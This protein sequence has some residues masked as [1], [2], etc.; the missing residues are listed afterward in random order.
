MLR[1]H[2]LVVIWGFTAILGRLISIPP[3]EVVFYR[4]LLAALGLAFLLFRKKESILLQKGGIIRYLSIGILIAAHWILFFASA[5]VAN[6]SV[7]LAGM[8]TSSLWTS[9]LEPVIL[10]RKIYFHE[11]ILGMLVIGGLYMIF[12]FEFDHALGLSLGIGSA[13]L[14]ALFSVL[15]SK[16]TKGHHHHLITF[17]EMTGACLAIAIFFP[18]YSLYIVQGPLELVP[19]ANDWLW[20]LLL[21]L[22]C[23]VYAY[24]QWVELM[25]RM[26]AFTTNLVVNL[27]PVYGIILAFIIFGETEKMAPG[28]YLGTSVILI[29][30]LLYP[31]VDKRLRKKQIASE[32]K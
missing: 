21:A 20:L 24:S 30:V 23:T 28:F 1:L 2:L 32:W 17:Y 29:S 13:F 27:E 19:Q 4:T 31:F 9:F 15:N 12:H 5:R 7:S 18:F 26:T 6:I 25:K 22:V 3:T 14:H 8:A 10:R 11:V 16:Y